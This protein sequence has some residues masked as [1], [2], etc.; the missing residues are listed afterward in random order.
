MTDELKPCPCGGLA[1]AD[2]GEQWTEITCRS[3]KERTC[4]HPGIGRVFVRGPGHRAAAIAAWNALTREKV[5]G[6]G[7]VLP[8]NAGGN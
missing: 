3:S 7:N 2:C 6:R 4:F 5:N 1:D 8:P